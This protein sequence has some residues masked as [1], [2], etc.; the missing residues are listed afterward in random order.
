M[1]SVTFSK[2][3]FLFIISSIFLPHP[4]RVLMRMHT[5]PGARTH[6]HM[7][8]CNI[9]CFSTTTIIRLSIMLY[10]HCRSCFIT[11]SMLIM[12]PVKRSLLMVGCVF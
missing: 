1:V 2:I 12:D 7:Q 3:L 5:R 11:K 10:I 4:I 9:H 6:V 8:I